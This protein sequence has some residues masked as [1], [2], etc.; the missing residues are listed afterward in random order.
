MT[1]PTATRVLVV[2]DH[3]RVRRAIVDALAADGIG[4]EFESVGSSAAA[5][6][7][8]ADGSY[9][10]AIVDVHL[11][12]DDGIELARRIR[13]GFPNVRVI[14]MSTTAVT[15]L[16]VDTLESGALGF[17]SK[18]DDVP[19]RVRELLAHPPGHPDDLR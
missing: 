17:V 18:S 12:P 10:V 3:E 1:I 16:P 6:E 19:A 13:L 9:D 8:L 7:A 4:S 11:G 15:D 2:D 5:L 14:L